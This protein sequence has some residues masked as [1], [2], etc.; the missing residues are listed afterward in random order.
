MG[1][2]D[3]EIWKPVVGYEGFY[4]VSNLGRIK[5]VERFV[6][7]AFRGR[8]VPTKIL[9]INHNTWGYQLVSLCKL[10]I[11]K[12]QAVHQLVAKSFLG[13]HDPKKDEVNH[14]DGNKDH[15][16]LENLE[17]VT[18]SENKRHGVRTGLYNKIIG[19]NNNQAKLTPDDI[20]KIRFLYKSFN[21]PEIGRIFK[22]S[23][24]TIRSII[25]GKTWVH[26]I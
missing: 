1:I 5:T 18:N 20:R 22:V 3:K 8:T 16:F 17:W 21:C 12:T 25:N 15:N 11:K 9:K 13:E 4:E 6:T 24:K 2:K 23:V 19:V 10:G 7:N 14:K 26:V